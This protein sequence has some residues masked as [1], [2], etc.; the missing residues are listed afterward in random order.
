MRPD[1]ALRTLYQTVYFRTQF[2]ERRKLR[3]CKADYVP[4]HVQNRTAG[5][6]LYAA[7]RHRCSDAGEGILGNAMAVGY[8]LKHAFG[9]TAQK[10]SKGDAL[11]GNNSTFG[12]LFRGKRAYNDA[13]AQGNSPAD[14]RA[15]R[16]A[17]RDYA[18]TPAGDWGMNQFTPRNAN[19]VATAKRSQESAAAWQEKV[20]RQSGPV[21][22]NGGGRTGQQDFQ[23]NA[24]KMGMSAQ[25]FARMNL[26]TNGAGCALIGPDG[27]NK[28]NF[29]LSPEAKMLA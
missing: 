10:A 28:A 3:Y 7:T 20:Q 2:N 9:G 21:G 22:E 17:A 4:D 8:A 19:A 5:G 1:V 16:K 6:F 14:S 15:A 27:D 13:F 11:S 24:K 29:E 23:D 26:E 18:K 25:Q 12:N